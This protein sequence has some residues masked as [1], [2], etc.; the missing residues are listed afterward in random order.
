MTLLTGA[1]R[2][3]SGAAHLY[4]QNGASPS[5]GET[6]GEALRDDG[7]DSFT[8]PANEL[9]GVLVA[10]VTSAGRIR[11]NVPLPVPDDEPRKGR[12]GD[13]E[14]RTIAALGLN[15]NGLLDLDAPREVLV[16][17]WSRQDVQGIVMSEFVEQ[18]SCRAMQNSIALRICH[19]AVRVAR[20]PS[21]DMFVHGPEY[22]PSPPLLRRLRWA[23]GAASC[24]TSR[25]WT[26]SG[27]G[28]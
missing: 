28:P 17:A 8:E 11:L 19:P 22:V 14:R 3:G 23:D 18:I 4:R 7:G 27:N 20:G 2:L 16:Q 5:M 21:V 10:G 26:S 15:P 24:R 12:K 9:G 1:N 13:R 6:L 25:S